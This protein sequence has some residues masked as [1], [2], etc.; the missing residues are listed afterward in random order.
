M[1]RAS[2]W[3]AWDAWGLIGMSAARGKIGFRYER[4]D[5][6]YLDGRTQGEPPSGSDSGTGCQLLTGMGPWP[7][8]L[9]AARGVRGLFVSER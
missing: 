1:I 4:T 5:G 9:S 7:A 2:R 3:R 8:G 6:R